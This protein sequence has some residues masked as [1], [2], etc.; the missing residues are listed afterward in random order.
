MYPSLYHAHHSRNAE[1]LHFWLELAAQSGDPVLELGC[2]TG[3][4]LIPLARA[5]YH[6]IGIDHD[7]AMLKFLQENLPPKIEPVPQLLEADFSHFNL[8]TKFPLIILPCNT[9]STLDENQRRS[10]LQCT[11]HHLAEEGTFAISLP[12]PETMAHL[13]ANS[14]IEL[15]DEFVHP[16]TGNPV[17]VSSSWKRKKH[18][19]TL[20]WYYDHLLPDGAVERLAVDTVH[21]LTSVARYLDDIQDAGLRICVLYGDYD[22]SAYTIDSP[23]LIIVASA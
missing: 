4:V 14:T 23:Y 5:G 1:D 19:L 11:R 22:R 6:C 16:Q 10:C 7:R 3:R 21:Q 2:G 18:T 8:K 9:L 17:Q 13:T 20:T 15:E 12:N